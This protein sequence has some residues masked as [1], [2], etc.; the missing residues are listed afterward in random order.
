MKYVGSKRRFKDEIH[1]IVLKDRQP[2]QWYVE[3]F[4]G[5]ANSFYDVPNPRIGNDINRHLIDLYI[6]A[7][8][9]WLPE[10]VKSISKEYFLEVR[11]KMSESSFRTFLLMQA[12]FGQSVGIN[13]NRI[14]PRNFEKK[15][16]S[17]YNSQVRLANVNFPKLK[18]ALFFNKN[19]WDL[20]IPDNSIIYCDPPYYGIETKYHQEF[21]SREFFDWCEKKS[22]EGHTVFVSELNAPKNFKCVWEKDY[23]FGGVAGCFIEGRRLTEKLFTV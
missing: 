20:E 16:N 11:D 10:H 4:I 8:N 22:S 19:Y 17:E 18:G 14:N 15:T 7:S 23:I 13:L 3:P 6:D 12:G 21:N 9:G 2:G 1:K 5:G